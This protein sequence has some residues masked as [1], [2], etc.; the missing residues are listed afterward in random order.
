MSPTTITPASPPIW[1]ASF[2][3]SEI[4]PRLFLLK[5]PS[6]SCRA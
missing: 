5:L 3:D 6:S 2:F 4:A 1:S